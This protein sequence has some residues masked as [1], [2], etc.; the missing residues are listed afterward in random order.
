RN[1]EIVEARNIA[2]AVL[3]ATLA[4]EIDIDLSISSG[5]DKKVDDMFAMFINDRGHRA[6]IEH[7]D[8]TALKGVARLGQVG[9]RRRVVKLGGKPWT[10]DL[11]ITGSAIEEMRDHQRPGMVR[12]CVGNQLIILAGRDGEPGPRKPEAKSDQSGR[13]G[14][15]FTV[16][17]QPF[18]SGP[19]FFP[20]SRANFRLKLRRRL[21][22]RHVRSQQGFEIGYSFDLLLA[23]GTSL[24][25]RF[26]FQP[27]RE[28]QL[29]VDI[30][31]QR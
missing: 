2:G 3:I 11:L 8:S 23:I 19:G 30:C 1:A 16:R 12:N 10:H 14:E 15:L 6:A 20:K 5:P 21:I 4:L 25:M 7:I 24:Q 13:I 18:V 28:V 22:S 31:V 29:A 26:H 27:A 9:Y 17:K